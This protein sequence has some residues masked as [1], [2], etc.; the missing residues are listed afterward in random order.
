MTAAAAARGKLDVFERGSIWFRA[1]IEL[2]EKAEEE[3]FVFRGI[4]G[5]V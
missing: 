2:A 3:G 1:G 5:V 4:L